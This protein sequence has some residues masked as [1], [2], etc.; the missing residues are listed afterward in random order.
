MN[1]SVRS[2]LGPLYGVRGTKTT[3]RRLQR[4]IAKLTGVKLNR[5]Q[6]KRAFKGNYHDHIDC[7][8]EYETMLDQWDKLYDF[9]LNNFPFPE[10]VLGYWKFVKFDPSVLAFPQAVIDAWR[11]TGISDAAGRRASKTKAIRLYREFLLENTSGKLFIYVQAILV[12]ILPVMQTAQHVERIIR[13]R[14]RMGVR[15][16][17]RAAELRGAPQLH[18]LAGTLDMDGATRAYIAGIADSPYPINLTLCAL[19]HED[20]KV[21]WELAKIAGKYRKQGVTLFDLAAD[22]ES[23]SGVLQW[24]MKPAVLAS[25]FGLGLTIHLWET[26]DPTDDD[27]RRLNAFDLIVP[28]VQ[29]DWFDRFDV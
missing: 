10:S 9:N 7:S 23:N 27:I 21:A 12:H 15:N 28:Q 24:W 26:N 1:H 18:T 13:E 8:V 2:I 25:L 14:V 29:E 20:P 4:L 3:E 22:E 17:E 6:S 11:G 16:G 19:R 5:R